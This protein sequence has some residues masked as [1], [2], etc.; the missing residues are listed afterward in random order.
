ME[1]E[2]FSHNGTVNLCWKV[3]LY[4]AIPQILIYNV[5]F[6]ASLSKYIL[7]YLYLTECF[8]LIDS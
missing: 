4:Y 6:S 3:T 1:N 7:I 5:K 2:T 8:T